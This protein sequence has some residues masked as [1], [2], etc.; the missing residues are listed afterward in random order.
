MKIKYQKNK[1][2]NIINK[3]LKN[4]SINLIVLGWRPS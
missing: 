4:Y 3:N 1:I 2:V